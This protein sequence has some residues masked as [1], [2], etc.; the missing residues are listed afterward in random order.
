MK[1]C[2]R[3][4]DDGD[5]VPFLSLSLSLSIEQVMFDARC[6]SQG[7]E[8]PLRHSGARPGG[9][10]RRASS[11]CCACGGDDI[12]YDNCTLLRPSVPPTSLPTFVKAG[13]ATRRS[14]AQ[15]GFCLNW[16]FEKEGDAR[17]TARWMDASRGRR[18]AAAAVQRLPWCIGRASAP[19]H[20]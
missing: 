3:D 6:A 9:R 19:M 1:V 2:T 16:F 7:G 11:S 18:A 8:R 17:M 5:D 15:A 10:G 14:M 4:G 13:R 20:P 12:F